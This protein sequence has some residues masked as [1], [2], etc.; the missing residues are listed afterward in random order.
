MKAAEITVLEE[1]ELN[2]PIFIEA[3]PG[4]GHVGKLVADHMVDELDATKFAEIYSPTFPPQVLVGEG[5]MIE[6]MI[7]EAKMTEVGK[8]RPNQRYN[9]GNARHDD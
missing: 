5:G 2:N 3:L 8:D 1:V 4:V 9:T 7:N 6:N